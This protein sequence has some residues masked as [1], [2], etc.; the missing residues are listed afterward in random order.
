MSSRTAA[1]SSLE[2][3]SLKVGGRTRTFE[4]VRGAPTYGAEASRKPAVLLVFHGSNQS[5]RRFRATTDASFDELTSDGATLIVY[6]DGYK[7]HWN[8][9]RVTIDF[10]AR[11]E[12]VDDVSFTRAVINELVAADGADRDR[13]Y[14]F[15]YS[16]GGQ[17]VLRLAIEAPELLAGMALVGASQPAEGNL[18]VEHPR[19]APLPALLIHGTKDP[20]V[21]YAG[22]VASLWGFRP[23]GEVM[24]AS[25]SARYLADRNGVTTPAVTT[26][27]SDDVDVAEYRADGTPPVILY[28]IRGG[29]HTVPGR[30]S[31][32]RIMGR[33]SHSFDTATV[34]AEFFRLAARSHGS[35]D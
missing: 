23:R 3:R 19:P 4:V 22:G 7:A 33:T 25:A 35:R 28:T 31:F 27:L 26:E 13:V 14:A 34:I 10:A 15:G 5:G 9:A 29:G 12:G 1:E 24:S 21:P 17:M 6:L 20:L 30:K 8:D 11:K 16:N 2:K 18:V 32:P